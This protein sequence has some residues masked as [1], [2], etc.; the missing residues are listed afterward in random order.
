MIWLCVAKSLLAYHGRKSIHFHEMRAFASEGSSELQTQ[1]INGEYP[2]ISV[3]NQYLQ[4]NK[5][6]HIKHIH[7]TDLSGSP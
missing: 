7:F 4:H 3:R 6:E 2:A 5:Y 1:L